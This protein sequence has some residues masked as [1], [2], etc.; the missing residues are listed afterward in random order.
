MSSTH[1]A[2]AERAITRLGSSISR[3]KAVVYLDC[4]KE[5]KTTKGK[6]GVM[7]EQTNGT[8]WI[9]EESVEGTV[10]FNGSDVRFS[11]TGLKQGQNYKVTWSWWD[12]DSAAR[13]QSVWAGQS[14]LL[15]ATPLPSHTQQKPAEALSAV[16]PATAIQ[17]GAALLRF[18][19]EAG[20]NAVV[21]EIWITE[22]DEAAKPVTVTEESKPVTITKD[23]AVITAPEVRAN[24]GAQKKIL[25]LTGMEHHNNWKQLTPILVEAFASDKR[26]EVSVSEQPVIMTKEEVLAKYDGYVLLYNN[27][28]KMPSPEGAL[29]N[30]KK[31]VEGGKGLVLVHF[32]SGAFYDWTTKKVDP[33]FCEIAGRV[34]NPACRGH[35]PHGTFTV[36]IADKTHPITKGLSDYEQIDELYTCIE[37]PQPIQV[38]ATGVSKVDQKVY[39]LAFVLNPGK[40][41]TFHCALGHSEKAFNEPTKQLFRQGV[42]WSVK[43]D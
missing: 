27:S 39:P 1:R 16:I 35:D 28:D 6:D 13:I 41:R 3:A 25:I 2:L 37:G 30:L 17:K 29:A 10:A 7:L 15:P 18:K 43:L 12:Y 14:Q 40:G 42:L 36:N 19:Q 11:L 9:F 21:S 8:G 23:F 4:G 33:A 38:L 20:A 26:L 5:A 22:T 24:A 32:S 31:A 34:W